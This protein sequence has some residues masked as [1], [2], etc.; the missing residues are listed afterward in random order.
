MIVIPKSFD[1]PFDIPLPL[2]SVHKDSNSPNH[3]QKLTMKTTKST[4][5]SGTAALAICIAAL[6]TSAF[7]QTTATTT[8][9]GFMTYPLTQNQTTSVGFP[10]ME[11]AN[12]TGPVLTFTT[13][14]IQ[15]SGVAWVADQFATAGNP[16]F[17]AIRSGLQAGRILLVTG[18][19][20]DTLTLQTDDTGLDAASFSL[21][22]GTTPDNF[23]LFPGDTL[24]TVFGT[25]ATAGVLPS[26]I[27]GGT[28]L[29]SADGVQIHNGVKFVSYFFNT[30]LSKWV[31]LNGGT[32][33]QK[34]TILYP[35]KGLLIARRGPNSTLTLMGRVPATG[36]LT[37]LPNGSTT[38]VSVR[39]PTDTTLTGLNFSGP[40]TWIQGS[41][42]T[43]DTVNL[44]NGIKW[45]AF[46]KNASGV[47]N[48]LNGG[49]V[50]QGATVIPAGTAILILK[51]GTANS[52]FNTFFSQA[53][54]YSL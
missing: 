4:L 44:W 38:A 11:T 53:L 42:F 54:P 16:Y 52:G 18:N 23:D 27:Q 15:A 21:V 33:D 48:M 7:S 1:K 25:T 39:F 40:G 22:T 24:G 6:S 29:L 26:G 47:W 2:L 17:V 34:D 50:D 13:S 41:S 3:L 5:R 20:T 19:T 36:L 43:A 35:D 28:S 32:T 31:M 12:Y 46:Y 10:L 37:K 9:V 51:H 45:V 30:T 8:P 49:T 14:T